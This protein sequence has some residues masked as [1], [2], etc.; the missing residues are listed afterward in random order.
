MWLVT[1]EQMQ[2]LDRQ[3]IQ[4]AKIPGTTLMER[5]GTGV[6]T[7]LLQHFGP[8]KGKKI[9][10]FCG[11]GN[12]GGDGLVVARLLKNKGAHLTVILMAPAKELSKDAKTMYR[13]LNK[14]ITP[15]HILALPSQETLAALTQDAH[16]LIDGLLG[17]GLS[18]SVRDPYSTAISAMNASHAYT[19]AID[20]PSGLDSNTGAILSTAIQADLTVTFGYPK[21]GLYVGDAIDN[22]GHIEVVDIGI[23]IDF[24]QKLAPQSHLLT[25]ELVSPLIPPRPQ[26]SH[27]GSFG[28]AGV[29]AGS[30]G[31]TG[32]AALAA[33]GAIR[34]GTGLVTAATPQ[35]VAPILESKLLEIMTLALPETSEH[36]LGPDAYTTLLR[37]CQNKSAVGFGPGLG[38]SPSITELLSQLLPQLEVPC[39]FDADALNNLAS[40]LDIFSTLKQPPI[41]TPHPGEMARLA[42]ATSSKMI[43]ED[44]IGIAKTFAIAHRVIL[45]LKGANTV[46]AN[47]QGQIAIC[48]TGNPGMAS[49]GMG[50]VL[51]GVITGFLAQG[52]TA[53]NAARSG[54]YIH[55]LAGDLAT[56]TVGEPGLIA[57]DL[58][59][60]IPHAL[61]Q[62]IS[63]E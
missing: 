54:V 27:K 8:V 11:K 39:V 41:L 22:V 33:L 43:N 29:V 36:L 28:H 48:P 40:H 12:N 44:R 38:V 2:E 19:V 35:T 57:S 47:P 60:A 32:A 13:R 15:S 53:W 23:P 59:S 58:I 56:L 55:G 45:V 4:D 31:K 5:A 51:T 52:L 24:V 46:I 1:P 63:G 49:A 14:T 26:S 42:A 10:V 18:S 25:P 50:D 30:P 16:I 17:T 61:T 7:H 21:I 3:T 9:V 20:I 34:A 37:F 62:T 6:V